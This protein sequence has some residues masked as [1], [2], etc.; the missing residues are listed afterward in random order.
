MSQAALPCCPNCD[1]PLLQAEQ[2]FCG[3]CGQETRVR[4]PTLLEFL[5]QFGG[6]YF[7]TEGALW[8]SLKLLLLPGALTL[9]YFRGRRRHYVLPLRLYLTIS[10]LLVLATSLLGVAQLS[11]EQEQRLAKSIADGGSFY[12]TNVGSYMAGMEKRQFICTGFPVWMC[13]RFQQKLDTDPRG[14]VRLLNDTQTRAFSHMSRAMFVLLPLFALWLK[15]LYWR[16]GLRYTEHLVFTLHLHSFWFLMLCLA[17]LPVPGLPLAAAAL[18]LG[19]TPL[20]LRRVYGGAWWR[21]LLGTALAMGLQAV[22]LLAALLIA[23]FW[24][25]LS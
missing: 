1:Q 25:L 15:L 13:Q 14:M 8:R 3:H 2:R 16:R 9:E 10:V 20:A 23:L 17:E 6:A 19:Y 11:P 18:M 21:T 22:A 12:L 4:A 24:A 5:Q 7:S